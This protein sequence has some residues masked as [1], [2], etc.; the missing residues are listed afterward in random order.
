MTVCVQVL[1]LTENEYTLAMWPHA[2]ECTYTVTLTPDRLATTF[3][4]TNTG[5]AAFD[6]TATLHSYLAV[7]SVADIELAGS[8]EGREYLDKL[9][10]LTKVQPAASVRIGGATDAV[11]RG[12]SGDAMAYDSFVCVESA[13]ALDSVCLA[14]Q[15]EWEATM[16]LVPSTT[17]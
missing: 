1:R 2:F 11:Y 10:G 17:Q 4:V 16:E 8:F 7:S 14:P 13:R 9:D 3:T 15:A 6:F 5:D 12:L